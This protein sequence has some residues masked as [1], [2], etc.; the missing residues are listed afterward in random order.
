MGSAADLPR[1]P[2]QEEKPLFMEDMTEQEL[3]SKLQIPGGIKNL[4]NTCY[5]NATVQCF[6]TVPE[7][8]KALRNYSSSSLSSS[9]A[10]TTA[11]RD[12]V[13]ALERNEQESYIPFALVNFLHQEFPRFAERAPEG[14]G[15][16]Q[17]DANECWVELMRTLN[18][19]LKVPLAADKKL[20]D[21]YFGGMYEV[22][23]RCKD[24]PEEEATTSS[25]SFL[26]LSCF[27]SQGTFITFHVHYFPINF[28]CIF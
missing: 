17:Q 20:I 2:R 9:S 5:M 14:G 26:Q 16:M 7:I 24:A 1:E 8:R 13:D 3:S 12:A 10:L 25:E 27:I 4:G 11:L 22:T 28:Q 21:T 23:M 15:F 6:K 18:N 19:H